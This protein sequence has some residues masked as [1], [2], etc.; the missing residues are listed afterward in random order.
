MNIQ[1][2]PY[3]ARNR[4]DDV[5]VSAISLFLFPFK[6]QKSSKISDFPQPQTNFQATIIQFPLMPMLVI[7]L[8]KS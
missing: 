7:H 6:M 1:G 5:L 3:L 4:I 8:R 2:F